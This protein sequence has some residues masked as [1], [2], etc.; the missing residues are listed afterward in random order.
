MKPVYKRTSRYIE[1]RISKIGDLK[2]KQGKRWID[3]VRRY[4]D[5]WPQKKSVI[6]SK[7]FRPEDYC[8]M[9]SKL[10][11]Q[12]ATILPQLKRDSMGICVVPSIHKP[13]EVTTMSARSRRMVL[14]ETISA[15]KTDELGL[16]NSKAGDQ[17][18]GPSDEAIK[19][20]H[21]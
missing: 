16:S 15:I 18:V 20:E 7:H 5:K 6:C 17:E 21:R 2:L 10:E 14:K 4:H 1:F 12:T 19:I 8:N 11:G 13:R 9:F 3:F